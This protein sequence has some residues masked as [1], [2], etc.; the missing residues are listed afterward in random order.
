MNW[1]SVRQVQEEHGILSSS[2]NLDRFD[3]FKSR[4]SRHAQEYL[5]QLV[6]RQPVSVSGVL[7]HDQ[8]EIIDN[9]TAGAVPIYYIGDFGYLQIGQTEGASCSVLICDTDEPVYLAYGDCYG[10]DSFCYRN[11]RTQ[12]WVELHEYSQANIKKALR[13]ISPTLEDFFKD[14][15]SGR[16]TETI[17]KIEFGQ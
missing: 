10:D 2:L 7:I 3:E 15:F 11:P 12:E 6:P 4:Y 16:L 14:T 13:V 9:N 17:G 5:T 8:A 1:K